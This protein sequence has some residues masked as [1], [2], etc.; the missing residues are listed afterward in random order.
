[1]NLVLNMS[2]I[3]SRFDHTIKNCTLNTG[4]VFDLATG[5]FLPG[6][7][8]RMILNGGL[9]SS[10]AITGRPQTYKSAVSIGYFGRVLRHYAESD[11]LCYETE[12]SLQGMKRVLELAGAP[13]D[14]SVAARCQFYDKTELSL[15]DLFE[16]I[17]E[18]SVE[19]GKH[20][21]E[22]TRETPFID[23]AGKYIRALVPTIIC[24]DSWSAATSSKE[25]SLYEDNKVGDSKTNMVAMN[26]GKIKSDFARQ[27]PHL[28]GSKGIYLI[29]T[30][31]IGDNNN[32][33]NPMAPPTKELPSMRQSDKLKHVG[34]QYS[35]LSVNMLE[36]RKVSPILDSNKK[37]FY[38]AEG[39][40]SDVE[41]QRITSFITRCKNNVSGA[42]FDHI[43][44]QFAGLQEWLEYFE[45]IKETKCA[46]LEGTQKQKLA[47]HDQEFTRQTIRQVIATDY[48]FRRALEVLGQF[49][50][51]RNRWNIPAI[52]NLGYVEFAKMLNRSKTLKEEILN[53]TGIWNFIGA[54]QERHY[55]SILDI[56][57]RV[58]Q[59]K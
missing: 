31:H 28:C 7:D 41:L 27:L 5:N 23:E 45:L 43:S 55:M 13:A 24:I 22:L 53:S 33:A 42:S 9:F 6:K 25:M 57:E 12:L 29:S 30:A 8:G 10:N 49:C 47:I 54:P 14:E 15:E 58:A 50:F 11:G 48:T 17:K 21:K 59:L 2:S 34:T 19:K 26:D 16:V 46:L 32:L 37:C 1:M 38:P 51:I 18:I 4:T 44:S 39:S 40:T 56:V 36:T 20:L 35:F 3:M 52:K